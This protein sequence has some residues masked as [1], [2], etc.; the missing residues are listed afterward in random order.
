M[1]VGLVLVLGY[2]KQSIDGWLL[3]PAC[4]ALAI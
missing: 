4:I 3:S 2:N 1:E